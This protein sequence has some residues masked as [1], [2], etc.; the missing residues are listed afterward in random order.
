LCGDPGA[1]AYQETYSEHMGNRDTTVSRMI[2]RGPW[3][4]YHYYDDRPPVLYNLDEDAGEDRDLALDPRYEAVVTDL[5]ARLYA[6]WDP[7]A[8]LQVSACLDQD[9]RL[10]ESW[11]AATQL[12][13]EDQVIVPDVEDVALV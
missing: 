6:G 12:D 4:L 9:L 11:G 5:M 1:P 10:L 8:I 2:R 7:P 3:K 13:H